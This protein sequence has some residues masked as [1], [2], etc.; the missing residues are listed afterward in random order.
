MD[1]GRRSNTLCA[2]NGGTP[3]TNCLDHRQ[4]C[5]SATKR[6]VARPKNKDPLSSAIVQ[7]L[8]RV[9]AM[10]QAAETTSSSGPQNSGFSSQ[11][12]HHSPSLGQA[13]SSPELCLGAA[14]TLSSNCLPHHHILQQNEGEL[15]APGCNLNSPVSANGHPFP[16]IEREDNQAI[17]SLALSSDQLPAYPDHSRLTLQSLMTPASP[18]ST[19]MANQ[20]T[21]LQ[22]EAPPP[23]Y[24]TKPSQPPTCSPDEKHEINSVYAGETVGF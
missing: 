9:E 10:L 6:R 8:A 12:Q 15:D 18:M 13:V 5:V 7:R 21:G 1:G 2:G 22:S 19:M 4:E 24:H 17:T 11:F 20:T 23:S 3:C 14:S 16:T